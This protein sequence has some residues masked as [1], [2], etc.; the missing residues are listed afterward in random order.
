MVPGAFNIRARRSPRIRVCS[1]GHLRPYLRDVR[2]KAR[3]GR[4]ACP[5]RPASPSRP[6]HVVRSSSKGT[7]DMG[8]EPGVLPSRSRA[9]LDISVAPIRSFPVVTQEKED[10]SI[11]QPHCY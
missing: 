3:E 7:V 11:G 6:S 4:E 9:D 8:L 10:L 1:C 5:R 2:R